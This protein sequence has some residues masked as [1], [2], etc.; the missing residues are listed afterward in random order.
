MQH[1]QVDSFS[2]FLGK[3]S[4]CINSEYTKQTYGMKESQQEHQ[5]KPGT[6]AAISALTQIQ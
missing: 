5:Y 2:R 3:H 6:N 4:C 1:R